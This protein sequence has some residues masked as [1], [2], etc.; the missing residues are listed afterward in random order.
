MD[1]DL[2]T[3]GCTGMPGGVPC[4]N[5]A[6]P[7]GLC[8][9]CASRERLRGDIP[10]HVDTLRQ[11]DFWWTPTT[12]P[13][14][15]LPD[16]KR[17]ENA[18][19][20]PATYC[21]GHGGAMETS[22]ALPYSVAVGQA[23]TGQLFL[24]APDY[25]TLPQPRLERAWGRGWMMFASNPV[26]WAKLWVAS[27][28]EHLRVG[29][30]LA[31]FSHHLDK[32][33]SAGLEG[34][35][36]EA[37]VRRRVAE[38]HLPARRWRSVGRRPISGASG[39]MSSRKVPTMA[40]AFDPEWTVRQ[41]WGWLAVNVPGDSV[42]Y[43]LY[44]LGETEGSPLDASAFPLVGR[45]VPVRTGVDADAALAEFARVAE[46]RKWR[47]L[48]GIHRPSTG[49][50]TFER[51]ERVAQVYGGFPSKAS[52][53]HAVAHVAGHIALGHATCGDE[54]RVPQEPEA[55][56]WAFMALA[57]L[58]LLSPVAADVWRSTYTV[59]LLTG[60]YPGLRAAA[61][62]LDWTL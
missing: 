40:V 24:P 52:R 39:V 31:V 45:S 4:Q 49:V 6:P 57:R 58:G 36:L 47:L 7:G 44:G 13:G 8:A 51:H 41:S 17:C 60:S 11:C 29:D 53:V 34:A 30:R 19:V 5:P 35:E 38:P 50:A 43:Q 14:S 46:T 18:V 62:A 54:R 27:P 55:E 2:V 16:W 32:A 12:K 3:N 10:I 48:F 1:A 59:D 25:W 28:T 33:A 56:A 26:A 22:V 20:S 21:H 37:E 23:T 15:R 61:A 9:S 42:P